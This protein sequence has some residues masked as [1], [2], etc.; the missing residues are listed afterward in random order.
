VGVLV[1]L[2]AAL[3]FDART[4]AGAA[5]GAILAAGNLWGLARLV[6]IYLY[7]DGLTW[8][9][10]GLLKVAALFGLVFYLVTRGHVTIEALVVGYATLPLGIVATRLKPAPHPAV[11]ER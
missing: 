10:V 4:A 5:V 8:G 7:S 2:L 3:F 9:L 1:V 11:E 6:R